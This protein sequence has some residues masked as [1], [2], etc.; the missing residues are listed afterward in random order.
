LYL[1]ALSL[2]L[3]LILLCF[4]LWRYG[5]THPEFAAA[6]LGWVKRRSWWLSAFLLAMS[7][8][9]LYWLFH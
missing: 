5:K 6:L 8:L 7:G 1:F 4:G 9:N 2:N 3:I